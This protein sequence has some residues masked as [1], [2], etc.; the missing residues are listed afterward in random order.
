MYLFQFQDNLYFQLA[1]HANAMASLL[2]DAIRNA[3]YTF[4]TQSSTNQ[5][6]PILPNWLIE[7]LQQNYAFYIWSKVD[8]THSAVR[9]VTSWATPLQ[10]VHAF[11]SDM[12]GF[13][14][15]NTTSQ[16]IQS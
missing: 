12:N 3:G 10:A 11:I 1:E 8:T 5:I 7:Q 15:G 13:I 4:L 9:L 16:K 6:F 14:A 2:H